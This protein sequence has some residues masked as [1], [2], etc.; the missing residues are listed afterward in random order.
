MANFNY[1]GMPFKT[2]QGIDS[3]NTLRP[4]AL[5]VLGVDS[6]DRF[7][8]YAQARRALGANTNWSQ[9]DFTINK[10]Q[11][12]L[13]GFFTRIALSEIMVQWGIPNINVK[14]NQIIFNYG[15]SEQIIT[16]NPGF[17][18]PSALAAA[19]QTS[20]RSIDASLA[21]FTMTYGIRTTPSVVVPPA[22]AVPSVVAMPVFEYASNA[23]SPLLAVGFSPMPVDNGRYKATTK[24]LFDLLGFSLTNQIP[25]TG[26]ARGQN[27]FCTFTKY[28]DIISTQITAQASLKDSSTAEVPRDLIARVYLTN[29]ADPANVVCSSASFCPVG[30]APFTLF[31]DFSTPKQIQMIPTAP[32]GGYL[33]FQVFDDSGDELYQVDTPIDPTLDGTGNNL[34]WSM[35]LLASEN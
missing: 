28:I 2:Y 14:T 21:A 9:W 29:P 26:I 30:C 35:T 31:R 12:I 27:T 18:T 11:S 3:A 10:K 16:L 32:I 33:K 25:Y 1:S 20:V 17:Y 22:P 15:T 8:S 5:S 23:V 34:E 13:T 6:E 4:A 19:I 7:N 24:Q